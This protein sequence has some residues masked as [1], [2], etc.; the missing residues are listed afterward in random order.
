MSSDTSTPTATLQ[1]YGAATV[2]ADMDE[3]KALVTDRF[4]YV[5]S[6]SVRETRDELVA[7]FEGGRRYRSWEIEE[8]VEEHYP[9]CTIVTGIGHLGVTRDGEPASLD[10]RFTAALVPADDEWRL[11]A[12]QT[13]RLPA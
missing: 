2:A 4:T 1:S 10:V 7:A 9:G 11:A 8:T 12:I 6:S 13:T 3:W 5:H